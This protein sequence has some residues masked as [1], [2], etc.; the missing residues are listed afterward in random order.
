MSLLG[1]T[2]LA[3]GAITIGTLFGM[4]LQLARGRWRDLR[5]GLD[6][7]RNEDSL[8]SA[9]STALRH[10]RAF[11]AA[12]LV[13]HVRVVNVIQFVLIWNWDLSILLD[14][15]RAT[16]EAW[17]PEA[18]WR[19]K[20]L[21]RT[22]ALVAYETLTKLAWAF[23]P[24]KADRKSSL[25]R[26]IRALSLESQLGP[27]LLALHSDVAAVL[28]RHGPLLQGIRNNIIGHR[29]SEVATQLLWMRRADA[30][31]IETLGWELMTLTNRALGSLR[32][33]VAALVEQQKTTS[34]LRTST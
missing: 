5:R 27:E 3:A 13:H 26:P 4:R 32:T 20:L 24:A 31:E 9:F 28:G 19:R 33:I 6:Q 14:L 22:L 34:V 11:E 1:T 30:T 23:D 25:W 21:G 12:G 18:G 17:N 15:L 10:R 29:D 16:P 8:E 7:A 2:L